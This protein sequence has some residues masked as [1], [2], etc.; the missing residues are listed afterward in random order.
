MAGC[1]KDIAVVP[2]AHQAIKITTIDSTSLD[3]N[4]DKPKD[5]PT[6]P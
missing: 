3:G 4:K 1:K 6:N 5:P 2:T